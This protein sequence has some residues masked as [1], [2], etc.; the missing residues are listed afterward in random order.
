MKIFADP[1]TLLLRGG[2]A[3]EDKDRDT[4]TEN[5]LG[6]DSGSESGN[7]SADGA[8]E[9]DRFRVRTIAALACALLIAAAAGAAAM[10][11]KLS[12]ERAEY[13]IHY[14][15]ED[16][17]ER[18]GT[19]TEKKTMPAVT[20]VT[21]KKTETE[22]GTTEAAVVY[23]YPA[24]INAAD[25]GCLSSVNG[26]N[27]NVAEEII[28]YREAHGKIHDLNELLDVYGVGERTLSVIK[29]HFYISEEDRIPLVT[30]TVTRKSKPEKTS[31]PKVTTEKRTVSEKA[32]VTGSKTVT[33]ETSAPL[34]KMN[35]VNIN[36]A[37]A[38]E[39]AEALLIDIELAEAIVMLRSNIGEFVNDLELLYVDGF[40]E[41]MLAERREFIELK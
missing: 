37:D 23:N 11:V 28:R 7:T 36:T 18:A 17:T 31:L 40:S 27:R 12:D 10:G 6:S 33:S 29:E 22:V 38:A 20:T 4:E 21:A 15:S 34:P 16:D 25:E 24:D 35:K 39:I 30:T 2:E 41:T 1:D 8:S 14:N 32:T 26:I 9:K 5:K 13:R 19:Q 3:L